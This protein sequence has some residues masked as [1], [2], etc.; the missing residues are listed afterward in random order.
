MQLFFTQNIK[1][2]LAI[3]EEEEARHC[4]KSLRKRRGDD[5]R[6][7][8]GMGGLYHATILDFGKR[9]V[10]LKILEK[11]ENFGRHNFHLHM[12]VAPTKN[13][14]R[15]EGFL[16]K[17]TEIGVDRITPLLTDH[18][19]RDKIRKDRLE[20]I[21]LSAT[22]QSLKGYLPQLDDLTSFSDFLSNCELQTGDGHYICHCQ[23]ETTHILDNISPSKDVMILIG[24]EGDFS[25][26]EIEQALE[27]GFVPT[28][29]GESRLRTETAGIVACQL[30]HILK[31]KS[32]DE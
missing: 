25:D 21:I 31:R 5:I 16:E 11:Q 12:V 19:E 10:S 17:A 1:G 7:I 23:G 3:L 14:S 13:I 29:I 20:R 27:K 15:F 28:N 2:D 24:P 22:K 6:F 4:I 30:A 32:T 26:S 9:D 18:S 8:D